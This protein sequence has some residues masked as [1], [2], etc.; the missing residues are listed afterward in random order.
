MLDPLE[1]NSN[2]IEM[3]CW[4]WQN[5]DNVCSQRS[6]IWF[7]RNIAER[8]VAQAFFVNKGNRSELVRMVDAVE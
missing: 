5:R 6:V 2:R 8:T 1:D 7:A 3:T 4:K